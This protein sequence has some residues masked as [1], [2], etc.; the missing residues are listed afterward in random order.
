MCF[1]FSSWNFN[2]KWLDVVSCVSY[3]ARWLG[4]SSAGRNVFYTHV[5]FWNFNWL[6]ISI[7]NWNLLHET[8]FFLES[9]AK[10]LDVNVFLWV[11]NCL[12]IG[13]VVHHNFN[14]GLQN[15]DVCGFFSVF[16]DNS[17]KHFYHRI[18]IFKIFLKF[19]VQRRKV[20]HSD[21]TMMALVVR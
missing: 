1:T 16:F 14:V 9:D 10:L 20:L 6:I 4:S 13:Y 5:F 3:D 19:P 2:V 17:F 8:F 12:T 18:Y 21:H 7:R 11:Q 15:K